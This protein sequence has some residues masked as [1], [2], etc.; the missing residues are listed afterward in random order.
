MY[1]DLRERGGTCKKLDRDVCAISLRSKFDK[2]LLFWLL[3]V[4]VISGLEKMQLFF[5]G[6]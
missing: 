3:K 6:D 5:G 2:M 4:E 1:S